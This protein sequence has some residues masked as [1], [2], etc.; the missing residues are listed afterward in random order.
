M[1]CQK[2]HPVWVKGHQASNDGSNSSKDINWNSRADELATWYCNQGS[3]RQFVEHT[4]H[5]PEA[6]VSISIN[7]IGII[8]QEE[9][10]L[11]YHINGYHLRQYMQL[12]QKWMDHV[13][14]CI[15]LKVFSIFYRCMPTG[16][17]VAHTK[18][19]FYQWFTGIKRLRVASTK[20]DTLD[21]CPCCPCHGES[22]N[23][24][25]RCPENPARVQAL[26][27]LAKS[28]SPT[29]IH[30]VFP[31]LKQGILAWLEGL[32]YD[33]DLMEFPTKLRDTIR[34]VLQDQG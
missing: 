30:P 24:I 19:I 22:T 14:D 4:D 20:D 18:F 7:G 34:T 26:K 11:R 5:T 29:E 28:L 17:Q 8:G 23:H 32:D 21:R 3:H 27:Q 10:S 25:H 13:W 6:R 9:D 2:F 15:D 31:L 1:L 16:D 33:P 12:Q